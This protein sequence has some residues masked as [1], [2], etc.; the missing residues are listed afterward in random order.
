V[1]RFTQPGF[2]MPTTAWFEELS[3][4]DVPRAGGKGANLGEMTRAGL[5]VPPGFVVTVDAFAEFLAHSG[6]VEELQRRVAAVNVDD[7][8]ALQAAAEDIQGRVRT[9]PIPLDVRKRI[10]DAYRTLSRRL[11][12]ESP[13]VA[14]RSSATAEDTAQ[15]SFAGMHKSFLNVRGDDAV[16]D[17]VRACWA[18]AYGARAL[19]YRNKQHAPADPELAVVVEA[20][21]DAEKSGVLFTVDPTSGRDDV[22]VIESA[23]GLGEVV[24]GGL[25]QPDRFVVDKQTLA[26]VERAVGHKTFELVRGKSGDERRELSPERADAPSL[27]DDEVRAIAELALKDERH[28]G[29]PQDA[30]FAFAGGKPFLVQTR[31]VTARPRKENGEILA[32]GLGASPG[33]VSGAVRVLMSPEQGSALEKGEILVAPMTTPDWVPILR[34]AA[35]IVTDSGGKTSHAAIVSRELGIPCI[36][37]AMNATSKLTNGSIVTVDAMEGVVRRGALESKAARPA[38]VVVTPASAAT[39]T[40]VYVN[41]ADPARAEE[42]ANE[43]VDGVGLLRAEFMILRALGGKHPRLLLER[44]LSGTFVDQLAEGI[45]AFAKAFH[46]RPVVY[47]SMD[48]R[49]NEFR[50]LEGGEKFE[51]REENPMIGYRGCFRYV[52]EPDLFAL[53]LEALHRARSG[54][55]NVYLMIPFVRTLRELRACTAVVDASELARERDFQLWI[56]AEVPSVV[57]WLPEYAKLGVR[58]VSIGSNDLTQLMLGVDRDSAS[59]AE[60]FDER[61]ESVVAAIQAIIRG[62]HENG[63]TSSICGQA[64]SIHPEFAEIL[65]RAGVDSISVT[66]DAIAQTRH[67]VDA[68]ERSM[69]VEAARFAFA[70]RR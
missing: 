47:R 50:G 53:E 54:L 14:V 52:K 6:L 4:S 49:T 31:P 29:A 48:F 18:S 39:A 2:A 7:T 60:L 12:V 5:P 66:P 56:M 22:M 21:I 8:A 55:G 1:A 11:G 10:V 33:T 70:S 64:P 19:F 61:D 63:M 28:Y 24:V 68:A 59:L 26:I 69:L 27:N 30:E 65:V 67:N 38:T 25:V 41:L 42:V 37:G 58:G 40:R 35:A 17:A 32:R 43:P 16:V 44:G 9:T 3:R 34:R 20:M 45:R 15:F 36:V 46:P 23:W 51:P 62:A 13:F 57:H